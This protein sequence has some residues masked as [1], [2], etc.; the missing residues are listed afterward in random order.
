[1]I[2]IKC[3]D[4]SA[5]LNRPVKIMSDRKKISHGSVEQIKQTFLNLIY[6]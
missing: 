5:D 6:S 3:G 1:M 2:R 4:V